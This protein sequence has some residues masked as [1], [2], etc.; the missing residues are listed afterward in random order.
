MSIFKRADGKIRKYRIAA[1]VAAGAMTLTGAGVAFAYWTTTGTGAG[2][3][4]STA[5]TAVT[6]V[7]TTTVTGMYPGDTVALSGD[8]NNPNPG[9]VYITAVTASIGTFSSQTNSAL[10]ACTQG[11]F[12]IT[13]TAPVGAE[14][15]SGTAVGSWSGLSITLTDAGTNQ[16]NCQSLTTIPIV[17]AST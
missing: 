14:I 13:G 6:V 17:Y 12:T 4:T 3:A 7:Q 8:F 2:N 15:L 9:M 11:D 16:D 1:I 5:P 10:P